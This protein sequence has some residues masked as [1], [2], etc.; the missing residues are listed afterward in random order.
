MKKLIVCCCLV[1]GCTTN[2][3]SQKYSNLP[4]LLEHTELPH[5]PR[6]FINPEFRLVVKMLIDEKGKVARAELL[7][8][9]SDPHWDS[10]AC[11]SIKK[12]KYEPAR[13]DNKPVNIWLVQKVKIQY[14]EPHFITLSQILCDSYDSVLVVLS[15]LN[16][17]D[18]FGA[19]AKKYSSDSSKYTNGFL[20]KKDVLLY[21]ESINRILKRLAVDEYTQPLK[22]GNRYVIFKRNKSGFSN[23]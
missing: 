7:N 20:G 14:E 19:L 4:M 3:I 5:I 1:F 22:Y 18:D 11:S 8:G 12:W 2:Q 13:I 9:S 17:G 6:R 16:K 15:K 23:G 21:P 10:L